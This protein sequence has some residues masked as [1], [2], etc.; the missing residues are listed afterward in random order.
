MFSPLEAFQMVAVLSVD[1]AMKNSPSGDHSRSYT[2]LFVTCSIFCG[3][4]CSLSGS[5]SAASPKFVTGRSDGTQRMT[6]PSGV[7]AYIRNGLSPSLADA[8]ICPFGAKRTTL[9]AAVCLES[10]ARY[11]TRGGCGA[12]SCPVSAACVEDDTEGMLG[13]TIQSC[14]Q[15]CRTRVTYSNFAVTAACCQSVLP[16]YWRLVRRLLVVLGRQRQ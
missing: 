6:L 7:S 11:S 2:C 15:S 5:S 12:T 9:T 13:W 8:S 10:V 1:P 4:Q 14:C 3:R 16:H